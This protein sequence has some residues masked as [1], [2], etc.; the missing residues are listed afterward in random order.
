MLA[1]QK[2]L[3]ELARK[4]D[5]FATY[6]S[7]HGEGLSAY[8]TL[9]AA[10][11][12][13]YPSAAALDARLDVVAHETQV[14][15]RPTAE[16]DGWRSRV[17]AHT[18]HAPQLPAFPF[19]HDFAHHEQARAW[20][21]LLRGVT[22]FAVDGSQLPPWRDASVPL[23]LIQVAVFENPHEPPAPYIKD[24]AVTLL[25]PDELLNAPSD[26]L[27]ERTGEDYGYS[28]R[29]THL[30]RYELEIE[31]IVARMA[32]LAGRGIQ[33]E[34]VVAFYDGSLIPSF[35][36]KAPPTYR[37]RYAQATRNLLAAS[38]RYRIPLIGF[39]DT[40]YARDILTMLALL[41]S[42]QQT[43]DQRMPG[44]QEA[45]SLRDA[46]LWHGRLRWGDRTPAFRSARYDLARLGQGGQ[47]GTSDT[48][49]A[50]SEG[51][52]PATEV[53]FVYLQTALDRPPARIEFP[54][55]MLNDG[56]LDHVM[57]VT[58]AEVIAGG[59]Y[60]YP[61]E[62]ADAT[63]VISAVDRAQFYALF[64]EFAEREGLHFTFSRKALSKSRR[65]L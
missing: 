60:P 8:R 45:R 36:L 49:D 57:D 35:A 52:D 55:W 19:A 41:A 47:Q 54:M 34:R 25:S 42:D 27:D 1:T 62:A 33:R 46:L 4:R 43:G 2:A 44:K 39:I 13:R 5:Q 20:A 16:Y 38:A 40:S 9:L 22:T 61:I 58:R 30:R 10:L 28:E 32:S 21:E 18:P 63:A 50:A 15:A 14:G 53:A 6:Q 29:I 26:E 3:E 48:A 37:N 11:C 7:Q 17:G 24:A 65:R 31:L 56:L 51:I 64:Q 59:G 12:E 23:A